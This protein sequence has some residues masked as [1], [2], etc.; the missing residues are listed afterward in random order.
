M[1]SVV[2]GLLAASALWAQQSA[3]D[4]GG[5]NAKAIHALL[6]AFVGLLSTIFVIVMIMAF[7]P[8]FRRH[9]GI[10]QEPLER[11]HEPSEATEKRLG[12]VV[13]IATMATVVILIGLIVVSVSV[14][15][16]SQGPRNPGKGMAIEVTGNQ[17]WWYV[18]YL[19]RR[20]EPHRHRPRTKST[21]RWDGQ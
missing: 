17:W 15:K 21:C 1:K 19:E 16:A 5:R 2:C 3:L 10:D 12:I 7:V 11:T 8:L 18:R 20:C 13:G 14:G 9:R 6:M 4:P